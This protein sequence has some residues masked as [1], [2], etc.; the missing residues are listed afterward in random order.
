MKQAH[1]ADFTGDIAVG[2]NV[3]STK[4]PCWTSLKFRLCCCCCTVIVLLIIILAVVLSRFQEPKV[5]FESARLTGLEGMPKVLDGITVRVAV[6]LVLDNPNGWP[7]HA[8]I[9]QVNVDINSADKLAQD[10]L[11]ELLYLGLATLPEVTEIK[12]KSNN[13][14]DVHVAVTLKAGPQTN[15]LLVRLTRDCGYVL[16]LIGSTKRTTQ[17]QVVVKDLI[18]EAAGSGAIDLSKVKIPASFEVP[19]DG[20]LGLPL[21]R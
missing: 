1:M 5:N 16:N 13:T 4:R 17:M 18:A 12:P 8:V 9:K 19:C 21:S 11:G 20:G 2:A 7:Y 15:A 10:K 14:L 3:E 6:K